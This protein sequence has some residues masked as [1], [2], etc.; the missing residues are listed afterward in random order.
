MSK[1]GYAL[2]VLAIIAL[3]V[4]V[5][6]PSGEKA[7]ALVR[8]FPG[9]PLTD[10]ELLANGLHQRVTGKC[11]TIGTITLPLGEEIADRMWNNLAALSVPE[12]RIVRGV[13][14]EDL[15]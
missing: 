12:T 2:L 14:A 8:V 10:Y 1:I 4:Y 15:S 5:F 6:R 9:K 3:A 11:V 13:S 7:E